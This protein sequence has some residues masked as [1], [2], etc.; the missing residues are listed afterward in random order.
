MAWKRM[1]V[2]EMKAQFP[3]NEEIVGELMRIYRGMEALSCR[4]SYWVREA[5]EQCIC[6]Y[7][8]LKAASLPDAPTATRRKKRSA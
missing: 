7:N 3:D 8:A 4:D 1:T 2:R 6:L 5:A